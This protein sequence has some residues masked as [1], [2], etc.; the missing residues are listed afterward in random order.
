MGSDPVAV[1]D[2]QL[3]VHCLAGLRVVNAARA[4]IITSRNTNAPVIMVAEQGVGHDP[5][6]R[7]LADVLCKATG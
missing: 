5:P 6:R 1:V 4:P 7:A 3:R 2:D